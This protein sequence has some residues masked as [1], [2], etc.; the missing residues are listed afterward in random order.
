MLGR[1]TAVGLVD[2]AAVAVSLVTARHR[3]RGWARGALGMEL[4]RRGVDDEDARVALD[5]VTDRDE[6]DRAR[7]L[8]ARRLPSTRGQPPEV[9]ARRLVGM[10]ARKGYPSGLAARVVREA[11]AADAPGDP[12]LSRG[13]DVL[14]DE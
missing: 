5:T 6:A 4:R 13:S 2:D 1:L 12:E 7:A 3:D 8:V 11:L 10:L 14:A 9:R